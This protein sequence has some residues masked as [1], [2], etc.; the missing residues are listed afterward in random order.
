MGTEIITLRLYFR[1]C[2]TNWLN[3][4]HRESATN[5]QTFK[6]PYEYTKILASNPKLFEDTGNPRAY[7]WQSLFY[8]VLRPVDADAVSY[9][10]YIEFQLAGVLK[11]KRRYRW[12]LQ[13]T[14]HVK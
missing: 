7:G 14:V 10:F 8:Y 5:Y 13:P 6:T 1:I 3:R 9:V 4:K 2:Y 12:K 11:T